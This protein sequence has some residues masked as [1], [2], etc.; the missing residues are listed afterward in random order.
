MGVLRSDRPEGD[1]EERAFVSRAAAVTPPGPP[2]PDQL[3]ELRC[4]DVYPVRCDQVMTSPSREELL[5]RMR[6]HGERAH[7][8]TPAWYDAGTLVA[9]AERAW[10]L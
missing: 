7:G 9:A 4:A 8:F 1:Q 6:K 5:A 2:L 3:F 10:A